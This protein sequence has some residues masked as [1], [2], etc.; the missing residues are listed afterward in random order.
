MDPNRGV[1]E[2]KDPKDSTLP[3]KT[4]TFDTIYDETSK[5]ID[6]YFG[7]FR[8]VVE[9]VLAGYN[10]TIFAYG[11]TGS[12]KTFTMEGIQDDPDLHGV[13]PN[14]I[15][16]IFQHIQSSTN[17]EQYLVRGSYLEI[18]DEEIYDLL[19]H[20]G[21]NNNNIKLELEL[22]EKPDVG[23]Y[24]KDLTTFVIKSAAEV[25]QVLQLGNSNRFKGKVNMEEHS[26]QSNTIFTIIIECSEPDSEGKDHIRVGRLIFVDLAGSEQRQLKIDTT[27]E[28][29]KEESTKTNLSISALQNLF[30]VC[31][32]ENA[33][34]IPYQDSKLTRLLQ[35][36][37]GG[38][39]KTVMIANIAPNS[40]NFEETLATLQYAN[41]VKNI[42]NKPRINID[43]KETLLRCFLEE[44]AKLK[45][46]LD[47]RILE[48]NQ[49]IGNSNGENKNDE[50]DAEE[51]FQEQQEKLDE[52]KFALEQQNDGMCEEEKQKLLKNLEDRQP[53]LAIKQ[54]A[55]AS[56]ARKLK[57]MQ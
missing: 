34:H 10:G 50:M 51:F 35:N 48:A 28:D 21:N 41:L 12:G 13:I 46:L 18:F 38:N 56:I 54:E 29:A 49:R 8:E 25:L 36:S 22:K 17:Q 4:F 47:Q 39:S 7:T 37:F 42:L 53:K 19:H 55:Q 14:A 2:V 27:G 32:D 43:L 57:S 5:E 15:H 6:L 26:S 3:P 1:I 30:S 33:S 45:S 11:Q 40:N 16:H 44:I 52:E 9:S 23:V 20:N 31:S 24:V